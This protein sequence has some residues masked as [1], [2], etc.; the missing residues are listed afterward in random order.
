MFGDLAGPYILLTGAAA[1]GDGGAGLLAGWDGPWRVLAG[2]P[3]RAG[4][5]RRFGGCA[6]AAAGGGWGAALF[7][8]GGG[9][10][11]GVAGDDA[12]WDNKPPAGRGF[13]FFS[14]VGGF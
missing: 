1:R 3:P 12:A 9:V 13:R 2:G 6:A 4:V 10:V 5:V 7:W 11:V 8:H 14:V